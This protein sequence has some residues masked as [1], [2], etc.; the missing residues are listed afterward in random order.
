MI[1]SR[2]HR[3]VFIKGLKVGGTSVEIALA[4]IC[5]P[6]DIVSPILPIDELRRLEINAGARNYSSNREVELAYQTVLR[7]TAVSDLAE[8]P[9]P[10]AV[11]FNHMPLRDILELQGPELLE[12]KILAVERCP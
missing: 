9:M 3:F 8:F 12:Y 10:P 2:R 6:E 1:L 7:Q 4:A 11:Y 5:G